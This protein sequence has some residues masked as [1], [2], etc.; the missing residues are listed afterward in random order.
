MKNIAGLDLKTGSRN[1]F[2]VRFEISDEHPRL[3]YM[4]VTPYIHTNFIRDS[5]L[6]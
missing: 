1:L 3:F 5:E 4:G 2:G 6:N